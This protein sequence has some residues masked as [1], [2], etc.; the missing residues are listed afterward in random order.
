MRSSIEASQLFNVLSE[1]TSLGIIRSKKSI[2]CDSLASMSGRRSLSSSFS[3]RS[4]SDKLCLTKPS[5]LDTCCPT[6][7]C[8]IKIA[9]AATEST[10]A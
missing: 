8:L 3:N 10:G 7:P 2:C 4:R 5:S 6:S 9:R 1:F